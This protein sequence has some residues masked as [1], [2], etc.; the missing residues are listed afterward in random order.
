M[1]LV[2]E[3]IIPE[4]FKSKIT[5]NS[6][7]IWMQNLY[8]NKGDHIFIQAPSGYG[9]TLLMDML[10]G[11]RMNY[12]GNIF[13]ESIAIRSLNKIQLAHL[14][15]TYLSII[16]QDNRL[17]PEMTILENLDIKRSLTNTI[18]EAQMHEMLQQINI[19]EQRNNAVKSLSL[20]EQKCVAILRSLLQP[21]EW[22]LLD[23]PFSNLDDFLLEK[24]VIMIQEIV[25]IN[26]AGII[27][28]GAEKNNHFL[29]SKKLFL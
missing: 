25:A 29:Y 6:S 14:R 24:L 1:E 26:K 23:E 28:A 18:S 10:Y 27:Y 21:F 12:D 9:K 7:D 19:Y 11:I 16:F 17:F 2:L 5:E 22:L 8:F 20:G 13:W 3:K 15:A 4:I